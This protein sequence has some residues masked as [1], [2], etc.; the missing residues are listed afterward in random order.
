M[1]KTTPLDKFNITIIGA[2]VIGLA[3]AEELSA[4]YSSVLLVE[5]NTTY[6]QET[7]SRHSEVIH[8]GIYYPAGFLKATFCR[9]GNHLLYETCRK[10]NI[11][12]KMV[13]KLIVATSD[14]ELNELHKIKVMTVTYFT[15]IP[16]ETAASLLTPK[17]E[18]FLPNN[19]LVRSI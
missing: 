19:V 7:S 17:Y 14:E 2:G 9:E 8:A 5:K 16:E 6:G 3:I 11:P 18:I 10:R 12:H 1:T 4:K 15:F 13:G